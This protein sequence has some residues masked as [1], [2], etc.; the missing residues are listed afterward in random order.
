MPLENWYPGNVPGPDFPEI[1]IDGKAKDDDNIINE[2]VI[3]TYNIKEDDRKFRRA[4]S[5]FEKQRGDYPLRREFTSYSVRLVN[6]SARVRRVL[7]KM[8]FNIT[9]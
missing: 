5:G 2:V 4:P 6:S 7:G 3:H 9:G 8:G 1:V